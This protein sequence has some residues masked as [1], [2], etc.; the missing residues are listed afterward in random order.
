MC[1]SFLASL[2]CLQFLLNEEDVLFRFI[3]MLKADNVRR[4]P[5]GNMGMGFRN[6]SERVTGKKY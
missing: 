5:S 2:S 6:Q 1:T 3:K 4:K